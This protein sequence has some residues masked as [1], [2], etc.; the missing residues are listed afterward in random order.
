MLAPNQ[1]HNFMQA[2]LTVSN[3]S[4]MACRLT[5]TSPLHRVYFLRQHFRGQQRHMRQDLGVEELLECILKRTD[6]LVLQTS[7][8]HGVQR[9][10]LERVWQMEIYR[11]AACVLPP[12]HWLSP[13]VGKVWHPGC[14]CNN[15]ARPMSKDIGFL[16][17][18]SGA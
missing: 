3:C 11:A 10:L 13:D 8:G 17:C 18:M 12:N 14:Q 16:N 4:P 15:A 6:P 2:S 7:C 9:Q 1:S 5:F